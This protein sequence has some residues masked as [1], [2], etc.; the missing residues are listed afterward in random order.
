MFFICVAALRALIGI[1]KQL[2][3][4]FHMWIR[5]PPAI[6]WCYLL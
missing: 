1:P 4:P 3:F 2:N 5:F 6:Y